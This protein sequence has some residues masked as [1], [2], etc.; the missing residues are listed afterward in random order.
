M[1]L[2]SLFSQTSDRLSNLKATEWTAFV[3]IVISLY[4]LGVS[5]GDRR[6]RKLEAQLSRL[7]R[8]MV[9]WGLRCVAVLSQCHKFAD[10]YG[11]DRPLTEIRVIS[12]ELQATLSALV[13]AGRL[14]FLNRN[15][16]LVG[17]DRPYANQGYRPV[18]L[19]TLMLAHE[20]LRIA[21]VND[22]DLLKASGANIFQARRIFISELRVEID[23]LRNQRELERLRKKDDDWK[24]IAKLVD[25]FETRYGK[26]FWVDRP[27]PREKILGEMKRAAR[28]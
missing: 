16:D 2:E 11:S 13:D 19:D 10:T 20:E 15:T 22:R 23:S 5:I 12:D 3:A 4:N 1:T 26:K 28:T 27:K 8:E 14:Y 18:I 25:D 17:R 6:F 21:G 7:D 9:A 24:D